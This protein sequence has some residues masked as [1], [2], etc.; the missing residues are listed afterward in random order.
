[1]FGYNLTISKNNNYMVISSI[2]NFNI[3]CIHIYNRINEIWTKITSLTSNLHIPYDKFGKNVIID[4][5]YVI[6]SSCRNDLYMTNMVYLYNL[7]SKQLIPLYYPEQLKK[8]NKQFIKQPYFEN[9]EEFGNWLYSTNDK[10]II[11]TK[12]QL[13]YF[14]KNKFNLTL[15]N[16]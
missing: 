8:I 12:K 7:I 11:G 9:K 2:D 4:D 1:M 16:E 14:T 15:I 13:V 10:I 6:I 3:G 5:E